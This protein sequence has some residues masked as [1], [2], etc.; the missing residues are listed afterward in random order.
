MGFL[1]HHPVTSTPTNQKKITNPYNPAPQ[2]LPIKTIG[3]F[4]PFEHKSLILLA[5]PCN[6]L[7]SAP[8]SDIWVCLTS[9]YISYT[10]EFDNIF[11]YRGKSAYYLNKYG[12]T[13]TVRKII[14]IYN[15]IL[16]FL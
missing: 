9:S 5:W 13:D 15:L 10:N 8:D 14:T 7:F 3:K 4:G 16:V 2:I 6:K 1:E 12:L 11:A